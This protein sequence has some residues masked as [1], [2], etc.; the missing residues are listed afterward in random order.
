MVR[1]E[2]LYFLPAAIDKTNINQMKGLRIFINGIEK[3]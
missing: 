3:E 1:I 2:I